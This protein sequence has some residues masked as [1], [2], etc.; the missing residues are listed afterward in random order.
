MGGKTH[1]GWID[2]TVKVKI[3]HVFGTIIQARDT[4]R[5]ALRQIHFSVGETLPIKSPDSKKRV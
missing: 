4:G 5:P 2:S 3:R 1:S